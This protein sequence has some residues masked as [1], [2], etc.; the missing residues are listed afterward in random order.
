MLVFKTMAD[1]C[2]DSALYT[3][4]MSCLSEMSYCISVLK[5]VSVFSMR[6]F[7]YMSRE[8]PLQKTVEKILFLCLK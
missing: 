2:E 1:I 8:L 6:G 5:V 7:H 4:E 3:H